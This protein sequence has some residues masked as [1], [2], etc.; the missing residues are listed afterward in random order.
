[1]SFMGDKKGGKKKKNSG[2]GNSLFDQVKG[3][4]G[5]KKGTGEDSDLAKT[6]DRILGPSYDYVNHIKTP[7]DLDMSSKGTFNQ[8]ADNVGGLL[9]YMD[10]LISG[11]GAMGTGAKTK[12]PNG[13]FMDYREPLGNKFFLETAVEC[14]DEDGE[15]HTRYIYVNNVP[16]GSIPLVSMVDKNIAFPSFGG[17]LPGVLSN[18]AQVNPMKILSAFTA[19]S[20]PRCQLVTM[21]VIDAKTNKKSMESQYLTNEDISIMPERWFP[22][23]APQSSYDLTEKEDEDESF[24]NMHGSTANCGP[25]AHGPTLKKKEDYSKMPNDIFIKIYYSMLGL[26]GIYILLKL[27]L[28]KK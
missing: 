20:A 6:Q 10:V 15:K 23:S 26:L 25:A 16:D 5:G 1:M 13:G 19:G 7:G 12:L 21:E 17:L 27:M 18:L 22:S 3:K 2:N 11:S 9:A 4:K 8:I 28:K 24:C 14:Q